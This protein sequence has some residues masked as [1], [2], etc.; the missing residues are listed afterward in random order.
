LKCRGNFIIAIQEVRRAV[1]CDRLAHFI[2]LTLRKLIGLPP[3][4]GTAVRAASLGGFMVLVLF[5]GI[6]WDL[7]FMKN[8]S[9]VSYRQLDRLRYVE[10]MNYGV[11]IEQ[12]AQFLA[13][14]AEVFHKK[15]GVPLPVLLSM[16]PGNPPEGIAVYLW[17]NPDI[18]FVPVFWWPQSPRLIPTGLRFSHRPSIYQTSPVMRRETTL[19]DY[20][21]FIFPDAVYS[22]ETF[23]QE[24]PQ[25]QEAWRLQRPGSRGSIVIFKYYP[26][27]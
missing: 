8:P 18:R 12:A 10:G 5:Q 21:H 26:Q 6:T 20:A 23:L 4:A 14:K 24:N 3:H 17:N 7:A 2:L 13:K 22:L 11:G 16:N 1:A 25:F 19:L 27:K 9:T 15:A